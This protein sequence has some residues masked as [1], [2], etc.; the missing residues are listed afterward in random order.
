[1]LNFRKELP[2]FVYTCKELESCHSVLTSPKLDRLRKQ[3]FSDPRGKED[4]EQI[5][6]FKMGQSQT[7]KD[8][9][10]AY[11]SRDAPAE[12]MAGTSATGRKPEL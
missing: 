1:M 2:V 10:V 4:T 8:R 9:A 6:A 5:T 3:L 11:L 7:N 12:T